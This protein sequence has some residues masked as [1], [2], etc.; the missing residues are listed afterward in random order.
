MM[1]QEFDYNKTNAN[2]K[3]DSIGNLSAKSGRTHMAASIWTSLKQKHSSYFLESPDV[4]EK[5][6]REQ[7]K[8][9]EMER[10]I[11]AYRATGSFF[12]ANVGQ[13]IPEH[14]L[15]RRMQFKKGNRLFDYNG[16]NKSCMIVSQR[17]KDAHDRIHVNGQNQ[18]VPVEILYKDASQHEGQ[19]YFF[20]ITTVRD[21]VNP[22]LG[23]IEIDGGS[24]FI[25]R[26]EGTYSVVLGGYDKLAVH[27]GR[28]I[29]LA[30][31]VDPR[32]SVAQFFSDAFLRELN[33]VGAEGFEIAHPWAEM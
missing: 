10:D 4:D 32:Y 23:G 12:G 33:A 15:P 18:F 19:F 27:E 28:V 13:P 26:N 20:N 14:L 3:Y 25:E 31:W 6:L 30:A 21:A 8:P 16:H 24:Y 11:K 9:L 22:V 2:A 17:F 7:R 1:L 29:G 5:E